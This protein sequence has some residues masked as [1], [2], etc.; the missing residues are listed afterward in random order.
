MKYKIYIIMALILCLGIIGCKTE[1]GPV[2]EEV[3]ENSSDLVGTAS[4]IMDTDYSSL[5]NMKVPTLV[6][7]GDVAYIHE[8]DGGLALIEIIYAGGDALTAEEWDMLE[9][10]VPLNT[11]LVKPGDE[12][13]EEHAS[14]I[15][16]KNGLIPAEDSVT[17]EIFDLEGN[18]FRQIVSKEEDRFRLSQ[19]G[20]ANDI[21]VSR[22]YLDY[23][24]S[25]YKDRNLNAD[26]GS[27]VYKFA[28]DYILTAYSDFSDH[29]KSQEDFIETESRKLLEFIGDRE[30]IFNLQRKLTGRDYKPLSGD[31]LN[32]NVIELE[33]NIYEVRLDIMHE[34][35][36]GGSVSNMQALYK[37]LLDATDELKVIAT[38]SNDISAS[39]LLGN[40]KPDYNSLNLDYQINE[41]EKPYNLEA[42]KE[43]L[44]GSLN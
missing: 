18:G 6:S 25:S 30:E 11:L 9:G 28:T 37:V 26:K 29:S 1:V 44:K 34:F 8:V 43:E 42:Q 12:S 3:P 16:V 33:N 24:F 10:Y 39:K 15:H 13:F 20:G 22:E 38:M 41:E 14:M 17:G 31:I 7:A 5:E 21:W 23:D 32:S 2:P 36:T 35:E 40:M 4:I 27:E 19:P